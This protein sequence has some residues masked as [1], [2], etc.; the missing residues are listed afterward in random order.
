MSLASSK[1]FAPSS[2]EIRTLDA[3]AIPPNKTKKISEVVPNV[4]TSLATSKDG[5]DINTLIK[6][7]E[8]RFTETTEVKPEKKTTT[9]KATNKVSKDKKTAVAPKNKVVGK[10]KTK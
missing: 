2:C 1:W 5:S 6:V 3:T 7:L 8:K 4:K 9:K 10:T